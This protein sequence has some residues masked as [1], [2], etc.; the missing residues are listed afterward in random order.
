MSVPSKWTQVSP[1]RR[2]SEN[3]LK[4]GPV[5]WE[6]FGGGERGGAGRWGGG[7]RPWWSDRMAG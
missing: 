3:R 6:V 4:F 7:E 1:G 5:S 2:K